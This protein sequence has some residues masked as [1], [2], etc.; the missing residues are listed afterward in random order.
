MVAV[1]ELFDYLTKKKIFRYT[2]V[3]HTLIY[4][5]TRI[6]PK[7]KPRQPDYLCPNT[8][9]QEDLITEFQDNKYKYL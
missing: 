2:S 4:W 9:I 5:L 8:K 1:N 7:M 3:M 6:F